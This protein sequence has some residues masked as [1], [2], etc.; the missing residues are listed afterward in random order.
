MVEL[1]IRPGHNCWWVMPKH[2]TANRMINPV[3]MCE[4]S[5]EA[6]NTYLQLNGKK[7]QEIEAFIKL[8]NKFAV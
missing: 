6:M 5:D 8:R 2:T 7:L 4:S 3:I 1:T